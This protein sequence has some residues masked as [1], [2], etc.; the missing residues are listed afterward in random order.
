MKNIIIGILLSFLL[1]IQIALAE[2][3][4]KIVTMQDI[5]TLG[6]SFSGANNINDKGQVVGYSATATGQNHAFIWEIR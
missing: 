6:G 3:S 1:M 2:T 5:G 4:D